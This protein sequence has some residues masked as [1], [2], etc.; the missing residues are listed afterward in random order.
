LKGG[1]HQDVSALFTEIKAPRS[2]IIFE[3]PIG[4]A[5]KDHLLKPFNFSKFQ[6]EL[7]DFKSN[8]NLVKKNWDPSAVLSFAT[9]NVGQRG[10]CMEPI[11]TIN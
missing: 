1:R 5:I 4:A 8:Q 2:E 9:Y 7:P 10:T 11:L 3:T 6:H